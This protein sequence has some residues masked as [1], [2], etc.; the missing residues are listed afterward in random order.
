MP[1]QGLPSSSALPDDTQAK[2]RDFQK[3]HAQKV[4]SW[5]REILSLEESVTILV[6]ERQCL[7]PNCPD[8][9][10]LVALLLDPSKD[11]ASPEQQPHAIAQKH[12]LDLCYNDVAALCDTLKS[13]LSSDVSSPP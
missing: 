4:K 6:G 9:E 11:S 3:R 12:L 2:I 7:E 10:T 13:Q 1:L 8:M 5:V